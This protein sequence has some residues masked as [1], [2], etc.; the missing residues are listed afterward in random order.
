MFG[1]HPQLNQNE[2]DGWIAHLQGSY[3]NSDLKG[4]Y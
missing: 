3:T 2:M 1:T 4:I